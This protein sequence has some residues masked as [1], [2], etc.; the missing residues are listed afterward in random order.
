MEEV[1]IRISIIRTVADRS[2]SL[3]VGD[4]VDYELACIHFR[5][6]L[7]LIAFASLVANKNRYAEVHNDFSR[8]WNAK[9]I[10]KKLNDIHPDFYPSPVEFDDKANQQGG[11]TMMK[12][13]ADGFLTREEFVNLYDKCS[14]VLHIRNPFHADKAAIEFGKPIFEW[15]RLMQKL[16]DIHYMRLVDNDDIWVVNMKHPED[17][18][19]HVFRATPQAAD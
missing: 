6:C 14:E 2:C 4:S 10:L 15:L 16:L 12:E 18:K 11:H 19:V 1:K 8:H 7:E 9:R 5:K 13:L 3:G 17:G